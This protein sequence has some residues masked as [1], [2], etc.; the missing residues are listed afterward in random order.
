MAELENVVVGNFGNKI[1]ITLQNSA[2]TAVDISG[3]TGT[4]IVNFRKPDGTTQQFTLA[5]DS[6]G[7]D[8]K[9]KFTPASGEIDLKGAWIGTIEL[10][11]GATVVARSI[12]FT[13]EVEASYAS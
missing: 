4:N 13:M 1:V 6:D 12:P 5:F 3:Y 8:G 11:V 7:T 9:V 10:K 2:G